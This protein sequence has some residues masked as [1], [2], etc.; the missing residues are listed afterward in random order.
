MCLTAEQVIEFNIS[1]GF[2]TFINHLTAKSAS[3][4]DNLAVTFQRT[5]LAEEI[6]VSVRTVTNYIQKIKELNFGEVEAKKGRTGGGTVIVFNKDIL[7]FEPK[8]NPITADTKTAEEIR[9][10]MFPRVIKPQPLRKYRT[11]TEI[12]EAELLIKA[13]KGREWELNEMLD[14]MPHVT[15]EFF[16]NFDE[17]EL[18][19]KAYLVSRMYNAYAVIFP[20]ERMLQHVDDT[21]LY[22]LNKKAMEYAQNWDVLPYHFVGTPAYN[23]FVRLQRT[24]DEKDIN[25]LGYLTTQFDYVTFLAEHK[26][27]RPNALPYVNALISDDAMERYNKQIRFYTWTRNRFNDRKM[28]NERVLY[29]GAKYPIIQA[30]Q[31]A[32]K[33]VSM[34]GNLSN[35]IDEMSVNAMRL[36]KVDYGDLGIELDANDIKHNN[37]VHRIERL[38]RYYNT[39]LL[40]LKDSDISEAEKNIIR[41]YLKEQV[42]LYSQKNS[43]S[44]TQYTLAFPTQI[45]EVKR[46]VMANNADISNYYAYIGN[47]S[48][49]EITTLEEFEHYAKQGELMDFSIEGANTFR[50]T[51]RMIAHDTGIGVNSHDV[52]EAIRNYGVE[53][54]PIDN[55]G[56][57]D[58][59]QIINIKED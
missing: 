9:D 12:T 51:S 1:D 49:E 59:A 4:G 7:N 52:G 26:K 16:D 31:F 34:G 14:T 53:K 57:L 42:A 30:L 24:F 2:L 19:Y 46:T 39:V 8:E 40:D 23:V 47:M 56:M 35:L 50:E 17:P 37:Y 41:A 11:K 15:R 32:Y 43:L 25:P 5:R 6:N 33:G 28:S 21:R 55:F 13:R 29:I 45:H 54:I 3:W 38:T 48:K 44:A 36:T 18:Y 20:R 10:L 22:N 58:L 27:A